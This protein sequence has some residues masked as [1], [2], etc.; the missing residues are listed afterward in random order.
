VIE[1]ESV[2]DRERDEEYRE[3]VCVGVCVYVCVRNSIITRNTHRD[4]CEEVLHAGNRFIDHSVHR[5]EIWFLEA[6][7]YLR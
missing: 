1:S 7:R 5:N 4:S 2:S 6:E 3:G